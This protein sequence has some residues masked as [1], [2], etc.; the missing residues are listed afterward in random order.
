MAMINKKNPE[1]AMI[2]SLR[3]RYTDDVL[4][5]MIFE[6]KAMPK[7]AKIAGKLETS[8]IQAWVKSH[9]TVDDVFMLLKLD[10]AGENLFRTPQFSSWAAFVT[11]SAPKNPEVPMVMLLKARYKDEAQLARMIESATKVPRTEDIATKLQTDLL[12]RWRLDR[13]SSGDILML[14]KL[15]KAGDDIIGRPE[16]N[17]WALYTSFISEKVPERAMISTLTASYGDE[18]L[19]KM[20][21][22]AKHVRETKV[23]A[24]NLQNAQF[25]NWLDQDFTPQ[26][27]LELL[28]MKDK[29]RE[30]NAIVW[31]VYKAN[32]EIAQAAKKTKV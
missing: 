28:G 23:M 18:A 25:K 12:N 24:T 15:N 13:K 17:T 9:E 32:Y 31:Y 16:F 22:T 2:A 14:L 21:E 7:T 29:L 1:E 27:V 26:K 20:L 30:P 8:R 11:T 6:A 10:E 3:A 5:K 4:A 19:S